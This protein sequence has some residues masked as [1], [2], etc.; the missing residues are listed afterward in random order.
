MRTY[1]QQVAEEQRGLAD[2]LADVECLIARYVIIPQPAL[3]AIA[4]W[5]AHAH[6]IEAFDVTPYLVVT[7]P[8]KR[9][10][11][12]R[13]LEVLEGLVPRAWRLVRPSEAVLFR[14]IARDRPTLLLD[15]VD[16]IFGKKAD[17]GT[18]GLRA[19]LN[20]GNRRGAVVSR[21][22]GSTQTLVDFEVFCAKIIAAIGALPDTVTDRG[23]TIPLR[24]K[25]KAETVA[26]FRLATFRAEAEPLRAAVAAWGAEATPTLRGPTPTTPAALDDRAAEGWEPLLAI[27]DLAGGDWPARARRAAVELH[28]GQQDTESAGVQ[29]LRAISQ[30]FAESRSAR[31]LTVELLAALVEREGEPWGEWWGGALETKDARGPGY[32][33]MQLLRPFGIVS[34]TV[35]AGHRRGKGFE[36]TDFADAFARYLND[37]TTRQPARD[38]GFRADR[39]GDARSDVTSSNGDECIGAQGLSP[40]HVVA[41]LR[42]KPVSKGAGRPPGRPHRCRRCTAGLPSGWGPIGCP[43]CG[44]VGHFTPLRLVTEAGEP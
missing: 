4:L 12:T 38:T 18:E 34:K 2:L 27:A 11:K 33:L 39:Q 21:C 13:L 24:R 6:A 8:E 43:R 7:S 30:V 31:L 26:R 20:A 14:K 9:C 17:Q 40:R 44:R 41:P 1:L 32:K 16:T 19:V 35:R 3:V 28:G 42:K 36:R 25:K 29:L 15:E 5:I 10:G 37:V 22:Q 23:T